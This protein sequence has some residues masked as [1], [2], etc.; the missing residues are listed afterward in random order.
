MLDWSA[1]KAIPELPLI[2]NICGTRGAP[3]QKQRKY[4][5]YTKSRSKSFMYKTEGK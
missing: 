5:T 4:T 2:F 3:Q 1:S